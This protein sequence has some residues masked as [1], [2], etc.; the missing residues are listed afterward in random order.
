VMILHPMLYPNDATVDILLPIQM[1]FGLVL[2]RWI[3]R[4][5]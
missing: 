1:C 3:L 5:V 2:K 4:H